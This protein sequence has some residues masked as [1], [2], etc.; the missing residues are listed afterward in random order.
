MYQEA[1]DS[2]LIWFMETFEQ[3]FNEE[4]LDDVIKRTVYIEGYLNGYDEAR[5]H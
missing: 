1:E 4:N 2:F 3:P 5:D